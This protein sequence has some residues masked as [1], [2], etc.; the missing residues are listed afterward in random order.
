M[1]FTIHSVNIYFKG[2]YLYDFYRPWNNEYFN[3][4]D[5]PKYEK[6]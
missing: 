4:R 3:E 6:Q 2:N 5:R 1:A